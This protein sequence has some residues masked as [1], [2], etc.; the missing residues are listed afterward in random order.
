MFMTSAETTKAVFCDLETSL[1][2]RTV[3][4]KK[5]DERH[6]FSS[7]G[8]GSGEEQPTSSVDHGCHRR[9]PINTAKTKTDALYSSYFTPLSWR[10]T[11][12]Y[13]VRREGTGSIPCW[14]SACVMA[15]TPPPVPWWT[16]VRWRDTTA[17]STLSEVWV[18]WLLG[19]LDRSWA[20]VGCWASER[21]RH[22]ES[23]RFEQASC[24]Q[25]SST[26][27]SARELLMAW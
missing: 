15:V 26:L 20:Q 10:R 4:G 7:E 24:R 17:R 13:M 6:T 19:L 12:R 16:N 25:M 5:E 21:P 14:V 11:R 22:V 1:C 18:G 3:L 23:Q 2:P 9:K 8:S 27:S